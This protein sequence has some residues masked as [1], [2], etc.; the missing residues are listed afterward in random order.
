MCSH[1]R[2]SSMLIL[3]SFI[4]LLLA[5]DD[6]RK[7]STATAVRALPLPRVWSPEEAREDSDQ[8]KRRHEPMFA[9]P[10]A[11]Q[12][13]VRQAL[14][15]PEAA[16]VGADYAGW[17]AIG[18]GIHN[19]NFTSDNTN[20][21]S[22]RT[23]WAQYAYDSQVGATVLHLGSVGGGLWRFSGLAWT[24]LS[25]NL[26]GSPSVGSF[27]IHPEHPERIL[28]GTGDYNRFIGDGLY[29]TLDHGHN[30]NRVGGMVPLPTCFFAIASDS[31]NSDTVLFA[32]SNGIWRSTDFGATISRVYDRA[33]VTDLEQDPGDPSRWLA[34]AWGIG[35]LESTDQGNSF[36]R[37]TPS[38]GDGLR[39]PKSRI[40]LA[41]SPSESN[42]VFAIVSGEG[43]CRISSLSSGTGE[44]CTSHDYC[45]ENFSECL[46]AA[47][48]ATGT[49]CHEDHDCDTGAGETCG[50]S[51]CL[52]RDSRLLN[53]IYRSEDGGRNWVLIDCQ[54]RIS[55]RQGCHAI[56][57]AV[58][59]S[60]PDR[61]FAAM[62]GLQ[63]TENATEPLGSG[64]VAPVQ[65]HR[66]PGGDPACSAGLPNTA[67]CD[68]PSSHADYTY[69]FFRKNIDPTST[70]ILLDNDGGYY[71]YDY[72]ANTINGMGNEF[73]LLISQTMEARGMLAGAY[74]DSD[75]AFAGLQDNGI[76]KID[77]HAPHILQYQGGG[78]GGQ[79]AIS[80]DNTTDLFFSDGV[81]FNRHYSLDQ[82]DSWE[83][84]N[85]VRKCKD[86]AGE[87]TNTTCS[88]DADC[89]A[90]G[91]CEE[92]LGCEWGMAVRPDPTPGLQ[93]EPL[94]FTYT[95][96]NLWYKRVD[97]SCD[98]EMVNA[99]H[100]FPSDFSVKQLDM[101]DDS[102][103]RAFYVT[104]WGVPDLGTSDM[105]LLVLDKGEPLGEKSWEERT[106]PVDART[107]E[108]D[109]LVFADRSSLQP[110]TIYYTTGHS[111]PSQ[112]FLSTD[113]GQTWQ[114][115]TGNLESLLPDADYFE[116]I[117]N[118]SNLDQLFLVT[119]VGVFWTNNGLS[120]YP[121]WSRYM[122]GLPQ[123][124]DAI[125]IEM[126]YDHSPTG[127]P[128]LHIG[129]FGQGF[130]TREVLAT[131]G[132]FV[133]DGHEIPGPPL[134]VY[135]TLDDEIRI[136]WSPSC[137]TGDDDYALYEGML[138]E[139]SSHLPFQC[140]TNGETE[141]TIN[142]SPGGRYYLV[143]PI[144]DHGQSWTEG[145]LGFGSSGEER[146]QGQQFCYERQIN[147]CP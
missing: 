100:P 7:P 143:T 22:G 32:T 95:V 35:I 140:T 64:D 111:R 16:D 19:P 56:A 17:Q 99:T 78:D 91:S 142:P 54:D 138:G 21:F 92:D 90:G 80:P 103:R 45:E 59:P 102:G 114:E 68:L 37:I 139:F 4:P 109:A 115:V 75:L 126:N 71:F 67:S 146:G 107:E 48:H 44:V 30:W 20:H 104:S 119:N 137:A 60:T 28:I 53:G 117:G 70:S 144:A 136:D 97:T 41:I 145:G 87:W 36:H 9:D 61:V 25:S 121:G 63:W 79:T 127:N 57:I 24:C 38:G 88:G 55:L 52:E 27:L 42:W 82:G 34:G 76:V 40:E 112:A 113:R 125:A 65:W 8:M 84:V 132:G 73:G 77:P 5:A 69:I 33:I 134:W 120:V 18:I 49:P 13:A 135:T 46:D 133:P 93:E 128:I 12:R 89:P 110:E 130:W 47:G 108:G 66:H 23:T 51:Q 81:D 131:D 15:I 141:V 101:A 116:L 62:G 1:S 106:P 14:D 118:P 10:A 6:G 85:C 122:F 124:T 98:W 96:R 105:R 26:E 11:Y 83:N 147:G 39:E 94:I 72:A 123:V 86:S 31:R 129:T 29:R 58:D 3:F 74:L 2:A 43:E 50:I